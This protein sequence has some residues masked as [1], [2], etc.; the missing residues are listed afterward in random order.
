MQEQEK[1][2]L[3]K[4]YHKHLTD[5]KIDYKSVLAL[6]E[7]KQQMKFFLME[8]RNKGLIAFTTYY[9]VPEKRIYLTRKC[10]NQLKIK[11]YD[12]KADRK[13]ELEVFNKDKQK[14]IDY[15]LSYGYDI[16]QIEDKI[17]ARKGFGRYTIFVTPDLQRRKIDLDKINK[18]T[19]TILF[20]V[21][22]VEA[23]NILQNKIQKWIFNK[24]NGV[25]DFFQEGNGYSVFSTKDLE[26]FSDFP[27]K[28]PETSNLYEAYRNVLEQ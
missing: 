28:I 21:T 27:R 20:F 1:I 10:L 4:L 19:K 17:I 25:E 8:L 12:K 6:S 14:L 13:L 15:L 23:K 9:S 5:G 18:E 7:D 26:G 22:S 11:D 2:F 16:E 24:Y 3:E